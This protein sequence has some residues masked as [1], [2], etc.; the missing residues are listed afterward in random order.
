MLKTGCF[1]G[2]LD[3]GVKTIFLFKKSALNQGIIGLWKDKN[4]GVHC[5]NVSSNQ[6]SSTI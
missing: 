2:S 6:G 1:I 4:K 3:Q 5:L